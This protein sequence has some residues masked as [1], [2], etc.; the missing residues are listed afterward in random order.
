MNTPN[1]PGGMEPANDI[2]GGAPEEGLSPDELAL[3]RLM[4]DAVSGIQP[5]HEA[6][7]HLRR[8]VPARRAHRRQLLVGS[9]AACLLALVAVPAALHAADLSGASGTGT[10]NA[11]SAQNTGGGDGGEPSSPATQAGTPSPTENGERP[12]TKPTHTGSPPVRAT[13]GAPDNVHPSQSLTTAAPACTA[14]DLGGASGHAGPADGS[15]HVSGWFEVDN[16]SQGSCTVGG[17]G[18]VIAAAQGA[19]DPA[20]ISV[21]GH[22]PGDGTSLPDSSATPLVL[23]PGQSYRVE[24]TWVPAADGCTPPSTP[25]ATETPTGSPTEGTSTPPADEE[26]PPPSAPASVVLSHTP[27][28][29]APVASTTIDGACAGTVYTTGVL[30]AP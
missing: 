11:S 16:V 20:R 14:G 29:G 10:T 9:A 6:L 30:S 24:F 21:V 23:G 12:G 7:D 17:S 3:R 15:G 2:H 18:S 19:A 22:T 28:A 27:E 26:Q 8:A 5:G 4:R 13:S 25:T 1:P